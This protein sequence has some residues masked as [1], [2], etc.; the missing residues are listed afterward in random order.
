VKEFF[1]RL[2]L[3]VASVVLTFAGLEI[4]C[5]LWRG[6]DW[7]LHWPGSALVLAPNT[8]WCGN[9]GDGRLGWVPRPNCS[10]PSYHHDAN[11]FRVVPRAP[12]QPLEAPLDT[13]AILVTGDSYA[14]GEEVADGETWAAYLQ[15]LTHREVIN[16]GVPG[17]GLDQTV[18]RSEQLAKA[19]APALLIVTFIADDVDRDEM[20]RVWG[21]EK[22]YF[23]LLGDRLELRRVPVPPST[24]A[25]FSWREALAWSVV[26]EKIVQGLGLEDWW[27]TERR[28]ALPEGAGERM[29]CPL[30]HRLAD[31]AIPTLV[32]AQY[33][34]AVWRASEKD[35]RETRRLTRAVL[36]CAEDAG[37]GALDTFLIIEDAVQGRGGAAVYAHNH[38]N[39]DG[40][41]LI[42]QAIAAELGRR[43]MLPP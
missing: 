14:Y 29:A 20:S 26:V 9:L 28:R 34:P 27:H 38:H 32:V 21:G 23:E 24:P 17:Y 8:D 22:P 18:M 41:R 43:H 6:P 13:P 3:V 35:A 33:L 11:G 25:G 7:L 15:A 39:A 4:A 31:L 42:A 37:L 40:N 36:A 16:A 30:L 2:G 19:I 5:R 12:G 10:A 1:S